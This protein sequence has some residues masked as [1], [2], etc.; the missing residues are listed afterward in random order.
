MA[1]LKS[2]DQNYESSLKITAGRMLEIAVTSTVTKEKQEQTWQ[3]VDLEVKSGP[4]SL[5]F[6]S[7]QDQTV[8][9]FTAAVEGM[10]K[11][12]RAYALCRKPADEPHNLVKMLGELVAGERA[13][14]FFEPSE[15][16]FELTINNVGGG[17]R[18]E[19]FVDAGN[20]ETG[21]YRWDSLGIRFFTTLTDLKSFHDELKAEFDC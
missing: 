16:S 1:K 3:L 5:V 21:I 18:V 12:A 19:L 14:L 11:I 10:S 2:E 8:A 6:K 7:D 15:P 4:R 20:V 17:F 9:D 13:K